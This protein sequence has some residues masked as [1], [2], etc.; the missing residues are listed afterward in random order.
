MVVN[1]PGVKL[2]FWRP[3]R[4]DQN[5]FDRA[6]RVLFVGADFRRKGGQ[7][8]LNWFGSAQ[9]PN[10]ELHIVTREQVQAS[11]GVHVYNDMAPNSERLLRP[12]QS[13]DL[14]VLPSLGE[15]FGIA[16]VEAMA[17]GLPVIASDVGGTA[18]IIE[19]GRNG[20]IGPGGDGR[21][22]KQA[23]ESI[24]NDAGMLGSMGAQSRAMA[25][26]RFDVARNARRTFGYLQELGAAN[27]AA[28]R[29]LCT[30][31]RQVQRSAARTSTGELYERTSK[32]S[33][34]PRA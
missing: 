21:A 11:P 24:L 9:R 33:D 7:M 3:N 30:T 17:A 2:N 19:L 27:Q 5:R 23:I 16:S 20:W 25:E 8:L 12:Y 34:I 4:A 22:L 29:S 1:P 32:K 13:S 6:P 31:K 10:C 14:F 26:E 18:D 15:C 28:T